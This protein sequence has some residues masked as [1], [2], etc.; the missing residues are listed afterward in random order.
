MSMWNA[1]LR[2]GDRNGLGLGTAFAVLSLGAATLGGCSNVARFQPRLNEY[3]ARGDYIG[4]AALLDSEPTREAYGDKSGLLWHMERGSVA[5]AAGNP[6]LAVK[7]FDTAE[8]ASAYNYDPSRGDVFAMWALNDAA[9]SFVAQPYEDMYINVFKTLAYLEQGK[10]DGFATAEAL[11]QLRKAEHLRDVYGKYMQMAG[12]QDKAGVLK[13]EKAKAG[14]NAR[15]AGQFVESPLGAYLSCVTFLAVDERNNQELAAR[16]LVDA[17]RQQ[18]QI[19]GPVKAEAFEQLA[20]LNRDD[21][22]VLVVALTG[23]GPIKT[24]SRLRAPLL[25][26]VVD[27]P[28]PRLSMQPSSVTGAMLEVEG[29]AEAPGRLS[30]VEDMASVSAENYRRAEPAIYSR[31]LVRVAGKLGLVAGASVAAHQGDKKNN[32]TLAA[33]TAVVGVLAVQATEQA[34]L[35]SWVFLPGQA[36]VML[37]KLPAGTHRV[38]MVYELATGGTVREEWKTIQVPE[39]GLTTVIGYNPS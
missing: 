39:R 6:E 9:A 2:R 12:A 10:I 21:V 33:V 38:R 17:I 28:Y 7:R 18:Q 24:E 1:I 15:D 3:H 27:I 8:A 32:Y 36:R 31:T 23:R 13:T 26:L 16:R 30:L 5:L 29:S 34:D 11:R 20:T 14:M 37:A 4:A 35:R 22:N 19:V 25:D